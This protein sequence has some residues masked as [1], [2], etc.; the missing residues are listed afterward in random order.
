MKKAQAARRGKTRAMKREL[1]IMASGQRSRK[2]KKGESRGQEA[3]LDLIKKKEGERGCD[4]PDQKGLERGE[5]GGQTEKKEKQL[6]L[7]DV[8]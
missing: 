8:K 1:E 5:R 6:H 2:S 4:N 3:S 7:R